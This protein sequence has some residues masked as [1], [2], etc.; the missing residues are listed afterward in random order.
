MESYYKT[1]FFDFD[2]TIHDSLH[3]YYPA[4]LKAYAYLVEHNVA[5]PKSFTKQEVSKWLGYNSV[6][7]W[8][9]FMP[10][11]PPVHQNEARKIIGYEMQKR[12]ESG[13]AQLYPG[14]LD[15]LKFLK[16]KGYTLVFISNCSETYMATATRVFGLDQYFSRFIC[17]AQYGQEPKWKIL[18]LLLNDFDREMAIIGDRFHDMEAG[19]LNG[20]TTV[21][22]EYGYGQP[23]EFHQ[24]DKM[25]QNIEQ[26][27]SI[28]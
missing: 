13:E 28:F 25:I 3:I 16:E 5:K 27:K 21:G 14:A 15:T 22:C 24:A 2:G 6:D 17:S 8:Q 19:F 20:I 4:F 7:M 11:C 18:K 9:N 10:D 26:L 1:L 12:L 23:V